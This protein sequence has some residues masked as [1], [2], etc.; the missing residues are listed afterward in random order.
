S[1][2]LK[3]GREQFEKNCV[4]CHKF[5]DKGKDLGPELTGVGLNGPSVLL[6][7]ILDPNRW[8]E[9]NFNSYNVT[10]KK[11]EEYTGLIK[12]ENTESVTLKNLEGES[13]L[14]QADIGS[15]RSSGLSFMPEGLEM[16]GEKNLRDIIGY[17]TANKPKGFQALD[18]AG[19]FT[20]DSRR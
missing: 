7:H 16:L 11:G 15:R 4:L 2:D 6:M 10:T 13:V 8:A 3:N 12:T 5:G 1:A 20:A 17:L 19:A 14:R 18:L 9:C